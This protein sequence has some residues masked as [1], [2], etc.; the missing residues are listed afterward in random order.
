MEINSCTFQSPGGTNQS[1]LLRL[2]G[3]SSPNQQP[4]QQQQQQQQPPSCLDGQVQELLVR[5]E[6]LWQQQILEKDK[7]IHARE[8]EL[9]ALDMEINALMFENAQ[10]EE[11]SR[12][13]MC[14]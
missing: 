4:P 5:N 10:C 14:V 1:P 8:K 13:M 6:L 9:Q 3:D 7:Q 12:Q 2:G 11:S